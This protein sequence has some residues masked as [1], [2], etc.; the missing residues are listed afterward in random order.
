MDLLE[1]ADKL[2]RGDLDVAGPPW[3][4]HPG[5]EK[6]VN[7][8]VP[9]GELVEIGQG[10][11]FV[12]S[13]ANVS[14]FETTEGL[15]CVDSGAPF[16]AADIHRM[17]RAWSPAR[18]DTT[19]FSHGHIDH[20]LGMG[21]FEQDARDKGWAPPR[22]VAHENVPARFDRYK[23]TAR[24]NSA[25]NSRQFGVPVPWPTEYRYPDETYRDQVEIEVGASASSSI[26]RGA[27]RTTTP[28]RGSPAGGLSARAI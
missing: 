17:I 4:E 3:P 26:M 16:S 20:V 14:A 8:F 25:I 27:R 10:T 9:R 23:L 2:W 1:L 11:A 6:A 21:P 22:V 7:P 12:N 15:V 19:I 5:N 24:Y 18:L 28:G 13:F